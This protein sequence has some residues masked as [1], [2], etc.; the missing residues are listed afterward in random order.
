MRKQKHKPLWIKLFVWRGGEWMTVNSQMMSPP[1]KGELIR[2]RGER[3]VYQAQEDGKI[4]RD[5]SV[6]V[7][8][9]LAGM[10]RE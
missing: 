10:L 2:L 3:K 5:G 1:K 6:E 4:K 9:H 8:G 7:H